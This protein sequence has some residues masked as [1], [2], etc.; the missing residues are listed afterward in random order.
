MDMNSDSSASS[1]HEIRDVI[2]HGFE[3]WLDSALA[4]E[5]PLPGLAGPLLT[6]IEN[7]EPLAPVEGRCDLYALWSAITAL[8]QEVKLQS[9]TFKQMGNTLAQLPEAVAAAIPQGSSAELTDVQ[10]EEKQEPE[11]ASAVAHAW[12]PENQHIDL[13]LD[14][15][16]RLERGLNSVREASSELVSCARRS[17]WSRWFRKDNEPPSQTRQVLAALEKGYILTLDRLDEAL[18]DY[19]INPI[20]CQGKEFDSRRMT[21]VELQQTDSV[22]EG[23]VVS[24]YRNGYEWEGEVYRSAQVKVARSKSS[25]R[26]MD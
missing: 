12:R 13:L 3:T 11:A 15:R 10:E 9:R 14:L 23:T 18:Q 22:P 21:A 25:D 1:V 4:G 26:E 2:L 16:D 7:G 19:H 17:R 8:T 6:A 5:Q 24:V 20:S